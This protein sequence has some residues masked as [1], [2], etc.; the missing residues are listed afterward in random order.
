MTKGEEAQDPLFSLRTHLK[1]LS[2][3]ELS[4]YV[5]KLTSARRAAAEKIPR[6]SKTGAPS[7]GRGRNKVLELSQLLDNMTQAERTKFFLSFGTDKDPRV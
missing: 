4:T 6:S 7:K 1:S 2:E 3:E 5:E